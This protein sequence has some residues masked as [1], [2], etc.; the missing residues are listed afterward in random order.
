MPNPRPDKDLTILDRESKLEQAKRYL[1]ENPHTSNE[2]VVKALKVS[3][4]LV[5]MARSALRRDGRIPKAPGD[6][7]WSARTPAAVLAPQ[8]PSVQDAES[9]V[10][11]GTAELL[12]KAQEAEKKAGHEFSVEEQLQLCRQ[13]ANDPNEVAQVRLAA[14]TVYNKIKADIGARDQLGPGKP[15]TEEDRVSRLSLLCAAVGLRIAVAAFERAFGKKEETKEEP[16]PTLPD[17]S[18]NAEENA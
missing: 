8:I 3:P 1:L 18:P 15:L 13:F 11:Q 7:S 2:G 9:L 10:V 17:P 12:K 14:L 6:R 16:T 5:S 4:R